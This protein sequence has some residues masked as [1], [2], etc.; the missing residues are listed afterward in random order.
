VGAGVMATLAWPWLVITSSTLLRAEASR[1][2]C[3]PPARVLL[4][5]GQGPKNMTE[6]TLACRELVRFGA[7]QHDPERTGAFRA[8]SVRIGA[9]PHAAGQS[10]SSR[11]ANAP[12]GH[13]RTHAVA[14][15]VN[16]SDKDRFIGAPTRTSKPRPIKVNP[17]GSRCSEASLT[18]IPHFMH[19]P[20]S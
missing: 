12:V 6:N 14:A 5:A 16:A 7:I 19:L 1:E 13:A 20:G 4:R 9:F 17:S 2:G 15:F 8:D 18:Q 11:N 10:R 3:T